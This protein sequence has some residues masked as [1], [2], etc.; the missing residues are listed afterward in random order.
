M[1]LGEFLNND[2]LLNLE[3]EAKQNKDKFKTLMKEAEICLFGKTLDP[4]IY[5]NE[6]DFKKTN[7]ISDPE[8]NKKG[9]YLFR[10]FFSRYA[11]QHRQEIKVNNTLLDIGT[12]FMNLSNEFFEDSID[13]IITIDNKINFF[14]N[15]N[16]NPGN[17]SHWLIYTL[18]SDG[19]IFNNN[20]TT[21]ILVDPD[22][23]FRYLYHNSFYPKFTWHWF[24]LK[25]TKRNSNL[26][27]LSP[28][29]FNIFYELL[30]EQSINNS[31]NK[32]NNFKIEKEKINLEYR[33]S[34]TIERNC[35]VIINNQ[36]L[37]GFNKPR[38][39]CER[40]LVS[41]KVDFEKPFDF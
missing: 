10:Y 3:E 6:C 9:L 31:K 33:E 41:G 19:D 30:L 1:T 16:C 35:L 22:D 36:F 2:N 8:L 7:D 20:E 37:H 38:Y 17:I 32:E 40:I 25:H 29:G 26:S 27:F 24:P 23:D 18:G 39:F 14:K 11:F 4:I 15:T 34:P 12:F 28:E 21:N 5:T 13:K